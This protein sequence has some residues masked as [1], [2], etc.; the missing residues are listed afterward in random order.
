MGDQVPDW[1]E[2]TSTAPT[3]ARASAKM[4]VLGPKATP[5]HPD[6]PTLVA[7]SLKPGA[8]V[9]CLSSVPEANRRE[10]EDL[11]RVEGLLPYD[12][13]EHMPKF[14]G[15]RVAV[16]VAPLTRDLSLLNEQ[17][18][19]MAAE[20][21]RTG[22]LT[23][24]ALGGSMRPVIRDGDWVRIE[25]VEPE[26]NLNVGR[27]VLLLQPERCVVHPIRQK[28]HT[29][30]GPVFLCRGLRVQEPDLPVLQEAILGVLAKTWTD[31]SATKTHEF[32]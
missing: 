23:F 24:R 7:Q 14:Q 31:L 27:V 20:L 30:H 11:L 2:V 19:E 13:G 1:L 4:I 8:M 22:S 15:D 32:K 29:G 5:G 12:E 17:E 6:W 28:L 9:F 25:A 3:A 18:Q 16:A 10:M 26:R 21:Q